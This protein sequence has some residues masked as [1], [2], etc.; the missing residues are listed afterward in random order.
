MASVSERC[1]FASKICMFNIRPV[2]SL[3]AASLVSALSICSFAAQENPFVGTWKLN[4][5]K[6]KFAPDTEIKEMKVTFEA[7]TSNEVKRVA[8]GIDSDG[9][10]IAQTS[11]ITWDG[12]D[13]KIDAP[14]TTMAVV[15]DKNTI[16][17]TIKHQGKIVDRQRATISANGKTMTLTEKGFDSKNH[18]LNNTEVFQKQ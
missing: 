18:P 16:E 2:H 8:T 15:R 14:D 4:A 7:S 5:A 1:Q 11:T 3:I 17:V 13:H 10:P 6:S 9:E 12:K